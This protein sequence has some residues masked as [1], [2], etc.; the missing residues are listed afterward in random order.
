[1]AP[2]IRHDKWIR[3]KDGPS[4]DGGGRQ[5]ARHR[6]RAD[7]AIRLGAHHVVFST[8][9]AAMKAARSSFDFII[10]T[11]PSGQ[12]ASTQPASPVLPWNEAMV[13]GTSSSDDAKIG[14]MTPA[15]FSFSGRCDD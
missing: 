15:V 3:S 12:A 9:R 11:V 4:R 6:R 10:S 13:A 1:M 8:D 5:D 2:R 7:D 14:G